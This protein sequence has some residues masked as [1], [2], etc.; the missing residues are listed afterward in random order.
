MAQMAL[1]KCRLKKVIFVPC[2][3]PPHKNPRQVASS[4]HRF[5]MV[6]LAISGN[7]LF[8]ISDFE[9]KKPGPSY[10]IDTLRYLKRIYNK[11]ARLFFIIGGDT[12]PQLKNWRYIE[13]ILR[14]ATFIVVNRPGQFKKTKG[15]AYLSVTMP[16]IDISSSY[17]RRCIAQG[18]T[19]KYFVFENV[20]NYIK[21][22]KLYNK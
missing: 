6:S 20:A 13:D 21:K 19:I 15:I 7:P 1:E 11:E 17:V 16:G 2:H 18:K 8:E 12:L 14:I 9:I 10:T 3:I 4:R 5:N 22:Y